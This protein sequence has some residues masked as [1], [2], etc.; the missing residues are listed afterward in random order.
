MTLEHARRLATPEE[1]AL[2]AG[3]QA[4]LLR[5]PEATREFA[6]RE[7]RL[8][9]L[10]EGHP[11]RDYLLFVATIAAAQQQAIEALPSLDLPDRSHLL[12]NVDRAGVPLPTQ[13]WQRGPQWR[14]ALRDILATL[15]PQLQPAARDPVRRLAAAS[16]TFYESQAD[17]LLG[18][19]TVGLDLATAPLIG[20][21]LQVY[22]VR[23]VTETANCFGASIF[24]RPVP[25]PVCPCCGTR[26]TASIVR[27]GG[28]EAGYRYLHCA[29]CSVQWHL[30]RIKC[31]HCLST[32]GIHYQALEAGESGAAT[33]ARARAPIVAVRAECC[34]ECGHYLKILSMEK[35]PDLDPVADDLATVALDLLLSEAGRTS[36]GVNLM[37]LYGDP[38]DG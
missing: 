15:A 2:R 17:R 21:A 36:G 12:A 4:P 30:V 31:S 18:A 16:D 20:A 34:D 29:L 33:V 26:P 38:G 1:I 22:W 9:S 10:A 24:D 7:A 3:E 35:D 27:I 23:L 25:E 13:H 11:M 28:M 32:R 37:L 8:R 5:L 19:I 6:Q 14:A